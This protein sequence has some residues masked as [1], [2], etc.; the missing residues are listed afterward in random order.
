[1]EAAPQQQSLGLASLFWILQTGTCIV[2][3]ITVMGFGHY[4]YDL[5]RYQH[6]TT[7]QDELLVPPGYYSLSYLSRHDG[8]TFFTKAVEKVEAGPRPSFMGKVRRGF[9]QPSVNV[10]NPALDTA[11]LSLDF[12]LIGVVLFSLAIIVLNLSEIPL[13]RARRQGRK[14][15]LWYAGMQLIK[16]LLWFPGTSGAVGNVLW[17]YAPERGHN[18][19]HEWRWWLALLVQ[20]SVASSFYVPSIWAFVLESHRKVHGRPS[21]G[22]GPW[23]GEVTPLQEEVDETTPLVNPNSQSMSSHGDGLAVFAY[24]VVLLAVIALLGAARAL[25]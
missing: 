17:K 6:P 2:L 12:A 8:A 20:V 9:S 5:L 13:L 19:F 3:P 15:V 22:L 21:T 23:L 18:L 10:L 25:V 1:M 14:F 11:Q 24:C 7:G 4:L 16:G